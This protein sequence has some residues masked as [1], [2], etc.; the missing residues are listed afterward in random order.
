ML[1]HTANFDA[2]KK[3]LEVVDNNLKKLCNKAFKKGYFILICADHGN[4]EVLR[5]ED[6]SKNTSHTLSSV[7]LVILDKDLSIR[8]KKS[9]GLQDVAPTILK[10]MGVEDNPDF[11]G[12]PLFVSEN[13]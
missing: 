11:E 7:K 6:G 4:A 5:N 13:L 10:L 8:M 12:K 1:G 3:G 2:V 9:G